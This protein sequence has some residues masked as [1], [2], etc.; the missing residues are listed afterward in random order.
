[1]VPA[2]TKCKLTARPPYLANH[3]VTFSVKGGGWD[4]CAE[5]RDT[6]SNA[7]AASDFKIKGSSATVGVETSPR[8]KIMLRNLFKAEAFLKAQSIRTEICGRSCKLLSE[9]MVELGETK[10]SQEVWSW[11]AAACA[12]AGA[13]IAGWQEHLRETEE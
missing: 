2:D 13:S 11:N 5:I 12:A 6:L 7:F 8:R 9:A 1:M 10:R 4:V 3:Q